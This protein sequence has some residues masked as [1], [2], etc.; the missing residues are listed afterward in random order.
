MSNRTLLARVS[1]AALYPVV[2]IGGC[3]LAAVLLASGLGVAATSLLTLIVVLAL[4]TAF[5][6]LLPYAEAW[7]PDRRKVRIDLTHSVVSAGVASP[8]VRISSVAFAAWLGAKLS[9]WLGGDLW[10][11]SWPLGLQLALAVAIADLGIYGGH[12]WM[13]RF[14]LGW[15]IHAVHHTPTRLYALAGGRSHPFNAILTLTCEA[16][17]VLLLGIPPNVYAL[18]LVFKAINGM[19]QHANI[20]MTPGPLSYVLATSDVHRFHHS[21]DLGESNTNF[22]N[23]TMLWDHVFGTFHLPH[24]HPSADVGIADADVP[25]SY[26]AHLLTP[27]TLGRFTRPPHVE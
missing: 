8:L 27:F 18:L 10:P 4:L 11:S 15:R 5:E 26:W 24:R 9:A 16:V 7:R 12:R 3:C 17:P 1:A 21:R 25:E 23:A 22:G 2:L 19:L 6:H 20:A 14:D 13:H